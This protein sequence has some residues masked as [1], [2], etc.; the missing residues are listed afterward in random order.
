[1]LSETLKKLE[2]AQK[3][4]LYLKSTSNLFK[5]E[6]LGGDLHDLTMLLEVSTMNSAYFRALCMDLKAEL[7]E[8]RN[9]LN[10]PQELKRLLNFIESL[11]KT[12]NLIGNHGFLYKKKL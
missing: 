1:M 6:N 11:S 12:N 8:C 10:D 5:N 9:Q 4:N 3:E 2:I 7:S